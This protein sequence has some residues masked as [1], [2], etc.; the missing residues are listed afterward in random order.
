V[1]AAC[2][3]KA[4]CILQGNVAMHF[5]YDGMFYDYTLAVDL[6]HSISLK[7]L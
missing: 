2:F 4:D 7:E 3:F 5:G 6:L 1:V